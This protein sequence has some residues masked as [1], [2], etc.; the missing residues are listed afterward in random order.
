MEEKELIKQIISIIVNDGKIR[1]FTDDYWRIPSYAVNKLYKLLNI[2]IPTNKIYTGKNTLII[3]LIEIID[4]NREIF[5]YY[6]IRVG[7]LY[8]DVLHSKI[9]YHHGI[10][11][12]NIPVDFKID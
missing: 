6:N 12:N 9:V 2:D 11:Y 3:K 10:I 4:N 7:K 8:K 1:H 5:S